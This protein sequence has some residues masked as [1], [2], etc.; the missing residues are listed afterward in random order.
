MSFAEVTGSSC[1]NRSEVLSGLG[2]ELW[3]GFIP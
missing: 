3:E 2:L 1:F